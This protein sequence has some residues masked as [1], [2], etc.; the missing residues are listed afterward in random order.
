MKKNR[1]QLILFIPVMV[2]FPAISWMITLFF[3]QVAYAETVVVRAPIEKVILYP[4]KALVTRK[5]KAHVGKGKFH[6]FIGTKTFSINRDSASAAVFGKGTVMSVRVSQIPAPETPQDK[7]RALEKKRDALMAEKA[8][9][10]ARKDAEQK[11]LAFI[12]AVIK[13]S[14]GKATGNM[15]GSKTQGPAQLS[16]MLSF[17]GKEVRSIEEN[18]GKT[19]AEIQKIND[20]IAAIENEISMLKSG[21]N[22]HTNGID[23]VFNS[24]MSQ[25]IRVQ[26]SYI[27]PG[28]GWSPVYRADIED[29]KHPFKLSFMAQVFQ[30]TGEDWKDVALTISNARFVPGGHLPEIRPWYIDVSQPRPWERKRLMSKAPMQIA[31]AEDTVEKEAGFSQARQRQ[32]AVS[33]EYDIPSPVTIRSREEE[34]MVPLSSKTL[35][36]EFFRLCIPVQSPHAYLVCRSKADDL[37]MPGP[38]RVFFRSRYTGRMMLGEK[39]AGKPFLIGLG[40]DRSI[41]I[42]REKRIDRKKETYFKKFTRDTIIRDI[43]YRITM[44]NTGNRPVMLKLLDRVPVSKTDRITVSD[45][46]FSPDPSEKNVDDMPGVMAWDLA[47]GPGKTKTVDISFTVS[48]PKDMPFYP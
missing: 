44:E 40:L 46:S 2:I 25:D 30:K 10:S 43:A 19:D 26:T 1:R 22:S 11:K 37:P 18:I 47:A 17:I 15:A 42:K 14:S 9:L 45:I 29:T 48:Y 32:T 28:A 5:G 27:T 41:R 13:T 6:L 20:R 12:D 23:I 3:S 8:G 38:V 7:I 4:E 39:H 21:K 33:K 36:G 34:T 24:E 35:T 16:E 31:R